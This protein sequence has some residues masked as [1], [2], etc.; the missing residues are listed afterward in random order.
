MTS[1]ASKSYFTASIYMHFQANLFPF[2]FKKA[3]GVSGSFTQ[4]F[5][6]STFLLHA[7]RKTLLMLMIFS[8]FKCKPTKHTS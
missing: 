2:R 3:A 7:T 8:C 6:Y 1:W 5:H 4:N